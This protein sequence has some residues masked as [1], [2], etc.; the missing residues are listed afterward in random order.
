[1]YYA[2]PFGCP[3]DWQEDN[4]S[5][6]QGVLVGD[7]PKEIIERIRAS[8]DFGAQADN[9][10]VDHTHSDEVI[11]SSPR[12][13]S[14]ID[15]YNII[16]FEGWFYGISQSLGDIDLTEVDVMEMDGVIRDV[17]QDAVESEIYELSEE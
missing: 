3:V 2:I 7:R 13:I 16:F 12:L 10:R 11:D 17:S 8:I 15:G 9:E 14:S 5:A 1:M 6:I 4:I